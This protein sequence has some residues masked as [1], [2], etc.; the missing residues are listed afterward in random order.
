MCVCVYGDGYGLIWA[1]KR[2][3]VSPSSVGY[4]EEDI[5]RLSVLVRILSCPMEGKVKARVVR[6]MILTPYKKK[7]Q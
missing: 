2:P 4:N 7:P 5:T 3:G 6:H 1:G